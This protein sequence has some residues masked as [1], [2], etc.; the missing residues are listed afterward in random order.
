MRS[1]SWKREDK[2]TQYHC[3]CLTNRTEAIR[4]FQATNNKFILFASGK[5]QTVFK[6]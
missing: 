4:S 6:Y 1:L 5:A 3:R 2:G